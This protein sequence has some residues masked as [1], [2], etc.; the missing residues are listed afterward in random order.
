[1]IGHKYLFRGLALKEWVVSNQKLIDFKF[2]NKVIAKIFIGYFHEYCERR[3]VVFHE[4][5]MQRI[6]FQDEVLAIVEEES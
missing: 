4:Q 1:M 5:E 6:F 2:H 3:Y